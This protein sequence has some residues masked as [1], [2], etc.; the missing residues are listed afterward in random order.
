MKILLITSMYPSAQKKYSGIFVKNQFEYLQKL[1]H[2]DE[3]IDIFFIRRKI[4]GTLGSISKHIVSFFR[5]V[6]YFFKKYEVVH[7]HSFFPLIVSAWAYKVL[8]PKTKLVVTFHGMD[9]NLQVNKKN[10]KFLR[11]F[12][13]KINV[14]IPVGK[15]VAKNVSEKLHLPI[16]KILPVGVNP[17]VFYHQPH[18]AKIY[19]Y[20][21]VGSFFEVKGIDMLYNSIKNLAKDIRFCIVGNGEEYKILFKQLIAE[22]YSIELIEDLS[23]DDLR[24][25]YN[26]SKFLVL[27]SRSEGFATVIVEAMYCGTPVVTSNIPQFR[28]QVVENENGYTFPVNKPEKLTEL[29]GNLMEISPSQYQA[30]ATH[31]KASF[32]K[33]SLD[34]VCNELLEIYRS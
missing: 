17:D 4:T 3:Q 11:F 28:E 30:L 19:D 5:F 8:H 2:K 7:L 22:G 21:F 29:L 14:T 13:K 31:A 25:V 15:E 26:Q 16:G 34:A 18:I 9:V 23:H 33:I 20:L 32:K 27:P 1:L 12:A 24:S 6:P 10:E